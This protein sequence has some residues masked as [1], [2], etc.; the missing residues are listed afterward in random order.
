M[1]SALNSCSGPAAGFAGG[2]V[3][4]LSYTTI[5]QAEAVLA[6]LQRRPG[7]EAWRR[8]ALMVCECG[9]KRRVDDPNPPACMKEQG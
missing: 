2:R 6:I 5:E 1:R 8:G 9:A 4:G 3:S 7:R